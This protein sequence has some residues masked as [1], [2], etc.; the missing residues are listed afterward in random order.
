M[1]GD[2]ESA[3]N[4]GSGVAGGGR[5]ALEMRGVDFSFGARQVLEAVDL[6]VEEGAFLGIIGPNGGG[7]TTLLEIVLGLLEPD[8]GSVSVLGRTPTEARSRIGYVPQ[9]ARFDHDFPIT[10]RDLVL[11][12][13]LGRRRGR[14][15]RW[16]TADRTAAG[17]ALRRME[18]EDREGDLIGGLSGGQL[19]RALIARA[20]AVEPEI[21]LLDEPTASVDTR[22]GR[23]V[24]ELLQKLAG[25]VTVVLVTH[26]VGVISR[27][28]ESLAC[29]NRRLH[30]HG[31]DELTPEL[32]EETYGAPVDM[33]AHEHGQRLL[34]EHG[35]A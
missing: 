19:Q 11:M 8:A 10:V 31:T 6:R 3:G 20:L 16:S 21:L 30:Y 9:H 7:K 4:R 2:A 18:L 34:D 28:V 24:Y 13:R 35:D 33:V 26:D 17:R 22:V 14:P 5:P 1:S 27:Y 12:G 15:G 29:L 32:L 25:S 23:N